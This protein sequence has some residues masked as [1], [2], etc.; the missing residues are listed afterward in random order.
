MIF[1]YAYLVGVAVVILLTIFCPWLRPTDRYTFCANVYL[2]FWSWITVVIILYVWYKSWQ[3]DRDII[4]EIRKLPKEE[5][6]KQSDEP[7]IDFP[8]GEI[9]GL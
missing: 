7:D 3:E 2:W 8:G 1:L 9:K 6:K 5:E 4:K